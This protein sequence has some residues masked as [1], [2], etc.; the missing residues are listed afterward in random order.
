VENVSLSGFK[1]VILIFGSQTGEDTHINC[2]FYEDDDEH[3]YESDYDIYD[4]A[5]HK[6]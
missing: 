4:L 2:Y 1:Y 6:F 5:W 3:E